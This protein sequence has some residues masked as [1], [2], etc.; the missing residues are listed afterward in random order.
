MLEISYCKSAEFYSNET[1]EKV[2]DLKLDDKERSYSFSNMPK[3]KF[4]LVS[5]DEKAINFAKE[6]K[7]N[8]LKFIY[9]DE[10]FECDVL[11]IHD[12]SITCQFK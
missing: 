1:G 8:S 7:V 10:E 11:E 3:S 2:F 6:H 4:D 5:L 9:K 12:D